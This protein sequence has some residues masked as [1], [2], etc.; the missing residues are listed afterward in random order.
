MTETHRLSAAP[1]RLRTRRPE[2]ACRTADAFRRPAHE[3][4]AAAEQRTAAAKAVCARCDVRIECRRQ[5]LADRDLSGVRGGLS[6]EE[7]AALLTL[8]HRP[9]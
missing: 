9:A 7:R 3:A 5:A 1:D 4:R 6:P 8:D 2:G